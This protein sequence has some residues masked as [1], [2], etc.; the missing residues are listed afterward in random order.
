MIELFLLRDC[1]P[2]NQ[3]FTWFLAVLARLSFVLGPGL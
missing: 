1:D 3:K 2:M